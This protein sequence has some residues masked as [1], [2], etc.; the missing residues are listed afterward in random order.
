MSRLIKKRLFDLLDVHY[1]QSKGGFCRML[2]SESMI[3]IK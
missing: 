1:A 3:W 2:E